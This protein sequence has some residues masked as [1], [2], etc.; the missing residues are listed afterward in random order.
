MEKIEGFA[1]LASKIAA[2]LNHRHILAL[3]HSGETDDSLYYVMPYL[4]GK[5]LRRRLDAEKPLPAERPWRAAE[6]SWAPWAETS[7]SQHPPHGGWR[8]G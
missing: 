3:Y 6:S 2:R 4:Q 1:G 8:I 5:S 7:G